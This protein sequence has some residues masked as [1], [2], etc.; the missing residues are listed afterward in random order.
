MTAY[1]TFKKNWEDIEKLRSVFEQLNE[2]RRGGK[3][4]ISIRKSMVV[5]ML[6]YWEC[7]IE[8][9]ILETYTAL[10]GKIRKAENLPDGVRHGL[11]SHLKNKHGTGWE[12]HLCGPSWKKHAESFVKK[13]CDDLNTPSAE[14]IDKLVSQF[15]GKRN[16]TDDWY[17]S[18]ISAKQT[19]EKL[20]Q[21][22]VIRGAIAHGRAPSA[23]YNINN[24]DSYKKHLSQLADK[25][26]KLFEELRSPDE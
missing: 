10:Y 18:G 11:L 2:G 15:C 21:L 17:W 12:W 5:L 20:E 7:Y 1:K 23:G 26:E 25:S 14:N 22:I 6:S 16:F 9:E 8:D 13:K 19:K 4:L 24:I 3:E